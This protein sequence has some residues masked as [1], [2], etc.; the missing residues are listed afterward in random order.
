MQEEMKEALVE[1][2]RSSTAVLNDEDAL[3]ILEICRRA[4]DREIVD[5]TE[6]YVMGQISG[7]KSEGGD[8][9]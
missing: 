1:A 2:V 6:R 3:A 7:I 9:E 8:V 5:A 4:T